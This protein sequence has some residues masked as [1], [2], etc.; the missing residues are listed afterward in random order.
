[1]ESPRHYL[2]IALI[3]LFPSVCQ[4]A[5][6]TRQATYT[7]GQTILSADVT[8]NENALF[9]YLQAGVDTFSDGT[10]VN[11]DISSSANIQSDKLNLTSIAQN[12]ANTGT[13]TN[14][15][16][17]T[18]TGTLSVSS[19][20]TA[21]AI[22]NTP[23]GSSTASTGAFSTLKVGTTNQGDILYD[24]GTTFVR[25]TPGT[26]GQA[27]LTQGTSANPI[28]AN[29]LSSVSD[30]GTSTSASTARQGTALK[31]AMG[32][33]SIAGNSTATITNLPFTATSSFYVFASYA[34]NFTNDDGYATGFPASASSAT[35]VNQ[36]ASTRTV[37][38]FAIGI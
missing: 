34:E 16:N 18:V 20:L 10:I 5:P 23:I 7:S 21:G 3:F 30:Y 19:T 29:T 25:L 28:F 37:Q 4:A 2:Y 35:I 38:W 22:Q 9:N 26:S 6:P 12:I 33:T 1:M 27:L 32:S 24:N 36:Q 15:G 17:A 31:V 14:T 8:A 11:A 13:L